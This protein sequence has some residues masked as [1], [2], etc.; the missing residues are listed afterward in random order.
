[1]KNT[2]TVPQSAS[3]QQSPALNEN[4]HA[5]DIGQPLSF[6]NA[7]ESLEEQEFCQ[8]VLRRRADRSKAIPVDI[9][10]L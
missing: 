8:K 10:A 7:L 4:K 9:D 6:K 5:I 1:M 2:E 3:N